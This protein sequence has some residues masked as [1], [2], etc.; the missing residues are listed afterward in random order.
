MN[1]IVKIG[2]ASLC[3][4]SAMVS[5]NDDDKVSIASKNEAKASITAFNVSAKKDLQELSN[6]EGIQAA[7]ALRQLMDDNSIF[8]RT[9]LD[10]KSVKQLVQKNVLVLKHVVTNAIHSNARLSSDAFDFNANLGVYTWDFYE[11]AFYFSAESNDIRIQFP[12]SGST[13]NDA[14]LILSEYK[15]E[16]VTDEYGET[17]YT[18]SVIKASIIIDGAEVVKLSYGITWDSEGF[19]IKANVDLVVAP[20]TASLILDTTGSKSSSLTLSLKKQSDI[21]LATRITIQYK[22]ASKSEDSIKGIDGYVQFKNLKLDGKINLQALE[23]SEVNWNNVI[24]A[25]LYDNGKKLGTIDF[26]DHETGLTAYLK[27]ADGSKEKLSDVFKPI[28][29]EINDLGGDVIF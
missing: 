13:T 26:V 24:K 8:Y 3:L 19:P 28:L 17:V 10:K 2:M 25:S 15:E 16:L 4:L 21:M 14:L 29:D 1:Q 23:T 6:L 9:S 7:Q 18:P 22:D 5:C 20:Y 12:T 11:E 27:Y